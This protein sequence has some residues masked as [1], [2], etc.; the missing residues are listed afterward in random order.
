MLTRVFLSDVSKGGKDNCSAGEEDA[1]GKFGPVLRFFFSF[2]RLAT[3]LMLAIGGWIALLALFW[4]RQEFGGNAMVF[5]EVAH[6]CSDQMTCTWWHVFSFPRK[7]VPEW[8]LHLS[9]HTVL[10]ILLGPCSLL[11]PFLFILQKVLILPFALLSAWVFL[12]FHYLLKHWG[13]PSPSAQATRW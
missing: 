9:E 7:A 13:T 3:F 5:M 4:Q 2:A 11:N 10:R 6:W 8:N 12:Y 1:A